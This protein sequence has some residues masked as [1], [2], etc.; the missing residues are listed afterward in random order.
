MSYWKL[1]GWLWKFFRPFCLARLSQ[2]VYQTFLLQ[3]VLPFNLAWE[4]QTAA[5]AS[6]PNVFMKSW[7]IRKAGREFAEHRAKHFFFFFSAYPNSLRTRWLYFQSETKQS[8]LRLTSG[9]LSGMKNLGSWYWKLEG[10]ISTHILLTL[11]NHM[12]KCVYVLLVKS[13]PNWWHMCGVTILTLFL[14]VSE[15]AERIWPVAQIHIQQI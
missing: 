10:V 7:L 13:W 2:V 14:S 9:V 3:Y 11:C 8:E 1:N 12:L 5:G 6:S 15:E 4:F